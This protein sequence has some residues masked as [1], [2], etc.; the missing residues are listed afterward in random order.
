VRIGS[1]FI[2]SL[3]TLHPRKPHCKSDS[4]TATGWARRQ[5]HARLF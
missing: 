1:G 4:R 2:L 5:L 3:N